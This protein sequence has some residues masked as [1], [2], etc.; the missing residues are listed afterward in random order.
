MEHLRDHQLEK[1][2]E[3]ELTR[4]RT[5]ASTYAMTSRIVVVEEKRR[6]REGCRKS[7]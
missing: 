7:L 1:M 6:C 5:T 3:G 4:A 2:A